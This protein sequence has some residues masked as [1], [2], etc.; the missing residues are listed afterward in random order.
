MIRT[1]I[2]EDEELAAQRLEKLLREADP[3]IQVLDKLESIESA[4]NWLE[5]NQHPDLLMLDIQLADGQSFDIFKKVK[6]DSFVIFTTAYDEY[7][8]KAFELNSIDYL[9]KPID[10]SKLAQSISK[11]KKLSK[12][13]QLFDFNELIDV[14]EQKKTGFKK[15]FAI[16]IG[17]KIKSIETKD[18]AYFYSLEKNTFLGNYEGQEYP[19]DFSLDKLENLVDPEVFFRINRQFIVN[20]HAIMKIHVLSKSRLELDVKGYKERMLVSTAKSHPFRLWIDK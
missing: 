5:E 7:A 3:E 14:I 6:V 8:I 9:L 11:F 1:L 20:Y 12:S 18:I 17:T 19:V 2:I 16:G 4:V 15:R 13:R 10:K